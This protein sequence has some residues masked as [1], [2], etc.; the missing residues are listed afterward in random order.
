[1]QD[2]DERIHLLVGIIECEG[3]TDSAFEAE[4]ALRRHRAVVAGADSDT[5]IVEVARDVFG[6]YAGYD[7]RQYACLVCGS[8]DWSQPRNRRKGLGRVLEQSMLINSD[9]GDADVSEIINR[10]TK[11]DYLGDGRCTSF[12]FYGRILVGRFFETHV[13][14]HMAATLVRR[15]VFEQVQFTVERADAC[16]TENFMS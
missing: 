9:G 5:M 16:R 7:K 1:M 2:S 10:R 11:A 12:E 6:R 3:R 15:H 4:M 8:T 14:N 13:S